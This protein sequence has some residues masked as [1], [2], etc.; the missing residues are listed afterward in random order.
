M[1][2]NFYESR[3]LSIGISNQKIFYTRRKMETI[4]SL[5]LDSLSTVEK[6]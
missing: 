2:S 1:H 4:K 3:V 6:R 5:T